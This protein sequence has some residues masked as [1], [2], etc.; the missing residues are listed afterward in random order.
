MIEIDK[1]LY[2]A[3]VKGY[4]ARDIKESIIKKHYINLHVKDKCYLYL[5]FL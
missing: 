3:S 2:E 5:S 1:M 4:T